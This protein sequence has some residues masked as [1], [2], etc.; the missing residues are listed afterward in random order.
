MRRT[1]RQMPLERSMELLAS[2]DYGVLSVVDGDG[3]P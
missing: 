2:G 1:D 3:L